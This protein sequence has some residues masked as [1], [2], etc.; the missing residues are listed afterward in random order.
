MFWTVA[1]AVPLLVYFA[2]KVWKAHNYWKEKGIP[3]HESVPLVGVG[4]S[5]LQ[6]KKFLAELLQ[7]IYNAF[8]NDK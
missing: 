1:L 8:P 6:G 4:I 3:Y 2:I 5:L 7:D